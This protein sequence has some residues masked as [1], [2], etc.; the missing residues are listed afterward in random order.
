VR[1]IFNVLEQE[2]LIKHA[3]IVAPNETVGAVYRESNRHHDVTDRSSD[4]GDGGLILLGAHEDRVAEKLS[5]VNASGAAFTVR[6][7]KQ[8]N[9]AHF[10]AMITVTVTFVNS[11]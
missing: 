1:R 7:A 9:I 3:A 2:G 6:R 5:Y 11:H 10:V 8:V 4:C